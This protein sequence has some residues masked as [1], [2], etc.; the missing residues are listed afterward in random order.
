VAAI[1]TKPRRHDYSTAANVPQIRHPFFTSSATA[2]GSWEDIMAK[3]TLDTTG[4]PDRSPKK[5]RLDPRSSNPLPDRADR[6]S[7]LSD[8]LILRVLS[9]L[10]VQ[11]LNICQRLS[12]RLH[13]I[14]TDSQL[15]KAAY[16]NRFVRPRASRLPGIK[17]LET[18]ESHLYFSSKLSKWLDEESLV[19]KGT[20]TNWKRQYRLRHNW[21]KGRCNVSEFRVAEQRP[22]PPSL[23]RLHDGIVYTADAIAGLRAWNTRKMTRLIGSWQV[24]VEAVPTALAVD[25]SSTVDRHTVII[26]YKDG[27]FTVLQFHLDRG[28]FT[29]TFSH[30]ASSN[31]MLTAVACCSP[32]LVTMTAAQLLSLYRLSDSPAGDTS[33]KLL[34][35]LRSHTVWPPL[36]LSLRLTGSIYVATMAFVIPTIL[37]WTVGLQEIRLDSDGELLGSR[38]ATSSPGYQ[39]TLGSTLTPSSHSNWASSPVSFTAAAPAFSKPTSL[40]YTHPYLLLSHL[41][42]TL[43]LYMVNSTAEDLDISSGTRLWGHTSS[44]SGAH[45]E[46]RGK[47]VSVSARGDELRIWELEGSS[48]RRK[49]VGTLQS[50]RITPEKRGVTDQDVRNNDEGVMRGWVGFDDESVVVLK[51]RMIGGQD[52]VVYDFT[53]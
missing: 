21:Q 32:F 35:S 49:A 26:G 9:F 51:E 37:S 8:E 36:S 1:D 12:R 3:R 5:A 4:T 29:A 43:T 47:A 30:P 42:N 10:S 44:V 19:R 7:Q 31:G 48:R 23:V 46:G 2:F 34:H 39:F 18:P 14:A 20:E 6:L 53:Y 11:E 40:S 38:L 17:D 28:K 22:I 27:S 52:L 15:W 33:P 13:D 16:Y 24:A 45:V 25:V 41:D 50:V